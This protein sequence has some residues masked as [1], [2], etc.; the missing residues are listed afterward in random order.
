MYNFI[1]TFHLK[2]YH[3]YYINRFILQLKNKIKLYISFK[4][5]QAFL[6]QQVS[7]YTVLRSPHVDKKSREQFERKTYNRV[8]KVTF[9]ITDIENMFIFY[10]FIRKLVKLAIGVQIHISYIIKLKQT[11]NLNPKCKN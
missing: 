3:P 7:K 10:Y 2:A 4:G 9:T 6:P 5:G 11:N 8:F 1:I